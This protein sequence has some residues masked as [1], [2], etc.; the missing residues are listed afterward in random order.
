MKRFIPAAA[1]ASVVAVVFTL[2]P[3]ALQGQYA[4]T[5]GVKTV[6]P[7][8]LS[9]QPVEGEPEA[10]MAV[11]YGNP[12]EAGHYVV[13]F[14]L[15]PSWAGRPHTHGFT[16]L[17]T[18][19]S[20]MLYMAYGDALTREAAKKFSPGAFIAMPAGTKMRGFTGEDECVVDVQ[21]QGPLTTQYLDGQGN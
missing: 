1:L 15:P 11:L 16:E 13:R 9:W 12:A 2:L 19:H 8:A 20:G 6:T 18:V 10:R 5:Q 17:I 3:Q 21:G 4:Q 14:K 7:E